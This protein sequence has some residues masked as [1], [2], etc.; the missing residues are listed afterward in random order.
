MNTH[1]DDISVGGLDLLFSTDVDRFIVNLM[2]KPFPLSR[3][4]NGM[5]TSNEC[6]LMHDTN[7]GSFGGSND[8]GDST[9]CDISH[10]MVI[11]TLDVNGTVTGSDDFDI[12]TGNTTISSPSIRECFE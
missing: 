9:D 4:I 2:F 7:N 5:S 1:G 12:I 10:L 11:D 3:G 6:I 8:S